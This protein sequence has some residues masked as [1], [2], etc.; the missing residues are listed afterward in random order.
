MSESL[1][2]SRLHLSWS[3]PITGE[4]CNVVYPLP[5]SIGRAA[6]VNEIVLNCSQVSR[7]HAR[8]ER[9]AGHILLTDQH[10]TNG[11][12]VNNQR[13]SRARL[14]DGD[15]FQIRPFTFFVS[16]DTDE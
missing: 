12:L 5:I 14:N 7:Q 9:A 11:I 16:T 4:C 10:S 2:S 6:S 1:K 13:I 8:L 15:S 3:N